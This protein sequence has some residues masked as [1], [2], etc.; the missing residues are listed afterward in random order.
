M[1]ARQSSRVLVVAG[2]M[3]AWLVAPPA[4]MAQ[5]PGVGGAAGAALAPP[6]GQAMALVTGLQGRVQVRRGARTRELA[7]LDALLPQDELRLGADAQAEVV[8]TVGRQQVFCLKGP[9]RFGLR[10][11]GVVALD[12]HAS[13][14]VR[15][16]VGDWP[17]LRLRPG[18]VG[19]ASISLRGV[20]D[21]PLAPRSPLGVQRAA[22]LE[23][24]RWDA[25]YAGAGEHWRYAVSVIDAQG[26][27]V[28][29]ANVG[30]TFAILPA[31][32][33]W[34]RG[35]A[36]VWSV[37][38]LGDSGRRVDALAE[39]RI[40][41]QDQE[42]D[43]DAAA[44]AA[45]Q[46]HQRLPDGGSLAEDVLYALWLEQAGLREDADRQW[47]RLALARPGTNAWG[48]PAPQASSASR[49]VTP[50]HWPA[51]GSTSR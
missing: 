20:P 1:G 29:A 14:T 47:Q 45:V 40:L 48:A 32:L 42:Q 9:G 30:E 39:F 38:A 23:Q 51:T 34:S 5:A 35:Q 22:A 28:Y 19:R 11:G 37:S 44:A 26:R 13:A 27:T 36:Y 12:R 10:A 49:F 24:L 43:L 50:M 17:A 7:L 21:L 41:S 18:L 15:D 8:V 16:L 6:R 4:A 2:W 25:P 3:L 46:A 31:E 33:A